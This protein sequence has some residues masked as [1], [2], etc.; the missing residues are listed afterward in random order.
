MFDIFTILNMIHQI[1]PC[2]PR[3]KSASTCYLGLTSTKNA[4]SL[5]ILCF[6]KINFL[7]LNFLFITLLSHQN[8]IYLMVFNVINRQLQSIINY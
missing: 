1:D 4:R 5:K 6:G 8:L 3:S 7:Q 2:K